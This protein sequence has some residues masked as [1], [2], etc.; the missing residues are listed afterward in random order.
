LS[1]FKSRLL[2]E[3]VRAIEGASPDLVNDTHKS[4]EKDFETLV[5]ERA[6]DKNLTLH[7]SPLFAH[8][9]KLVTHF[10]RLFACLLFILGGLAVQK[11][12]FT[13]QLSEINF[14]W[15]VT[16]F[17]IPNLCMLLFWLC[18]FLKPTLLQSSSLTKFSLA[19]MK[20]FEKRF[21]RSTT[22]RQDYGALFHCYFELHFSKKLGRY[23]LST[24]T[25][26][27]WLAYFVGATLMAVVML[28]T[29][30]VDFI[31]QTS[32]L[33]ADAFQGL[34]QSLA[35]F[36]ELLGFPVPSLEQIQQ[37]HIGTDNLLNAESRRLAWSSLLISSLFLYGVLPRL[38]LLL[39]MRYQYKQATLAYRLDFSLPYYVQLRQS[40]KPNKT[41]LGI[42]DADEEKQEGV[43]SPAVSEGPLQTTENVSL[44][45]D[46]Y[47]LAV[48]L[49]EQQLGCAE[50]HVKQSNGNVLSALTNVCDY[51][52]QRQLLT[53][54]AT[55]HHT[56]VAIYVAFNRVP[57]RGL[58]RFI[59]E[60]T[61][62]RHQ[63]FH[64]LLITD[65]ANN[66]QRDSDWYQL[67]DEVGIA[68]DNILHIN[69]QGARYE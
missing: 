17:F 10:Y 65:N 30:Q 53:D 11:M 24:L 7:V 15:A 43:I 52:A 37:S 5:Y 57:D 69:V 25:H 63:S 49:S 19:T 48:E 45:G 61:V 27:L 51:Q 21:N 50:R 9:N 2:S 18:L 1:Q 33:S 54:L 40:L 14:F 35:Y 12:L 64:L 36:P 32:I 67:A 42:T 47:P 22:Q 46:F 62:N 39:L 44:A 26:L 13:E 20:Q 34:T 28:A 16:L 66:K 8:F 68:L 31:W 60:L 56:S 55:V 3:G 4:H 59:R 41:T 23:Q 6:I 38:I 29:H 58:K